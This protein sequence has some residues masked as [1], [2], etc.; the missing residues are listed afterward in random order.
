[1]SPSTQKTI[2]TS[3]RVHH[4][5]RAV[6]HRL[7]QPQ[8][9]FRPVLVNPAPEIHS[10]ALELPQGSVQVHTAV[11]RIDDSPNDAGAVVGG[12]FQVEQEVGSREASAYALLKTEDMEG[13]QLLF[14]LLND[15]LQRLHLNGSTQIIAQERGEEQLQNFGDSGTQ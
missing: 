7:Y 10:A 9:V 1:M 11:D 15:L 6:S 3:P 5:T 4:T 2:A 8:G 14:E 13:E 12:M